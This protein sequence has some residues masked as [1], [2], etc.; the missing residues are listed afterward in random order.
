MARKIGNQ[1]TVFVCKEVCDRENIYSQI[2]V[3]ALK[4]AMEH[5]TN[6]QFKV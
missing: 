1:K 2:N 4:N 6:A 5:L 3:D